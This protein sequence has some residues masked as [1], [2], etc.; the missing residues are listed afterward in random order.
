MISLTKLID[1]LSGYIAKVQKDVS[2]R[3]RQRQ[4]ATPKISGAATLLSA[5]QATKAAIVNRLTAEINEIKSG[6]SNMRQGLQ[7]VDVA[8]AAYDDIL[9]ILEDMQKKVSNAQTSEDLNTSVATD[10]AALTTAFDGFSQQ[11]SAV[12]ANRQVGNE[13]LI[14]GNKYQKRIG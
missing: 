10:A 12:I 5:E 3:D 2:D 7:T 11:I 4:Q 1:P 13:N 9:A 6:L 14:D 8:E